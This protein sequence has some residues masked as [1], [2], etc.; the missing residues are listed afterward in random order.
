MGCRNE[1]RRP[2]KFKRALGPPYI[3]YITLYTADVGS[4]TGPLLSPTMVAV[5]RH[6][7]S[8]WIQEPTPNSI[9]LDLKIFNCDRWTSCFSNIF[10]W[11]SILYRS[12]TPGEMIRGRCWRGGLSIT[13]RVADSGPSPVM[14]WRCPCLFFQ[15]RGA[16]RA[17]FACLR[18]TGRF[19]FSDWLPEVF[20]LFW[21]LIFT[22]LHQWQSPFETETFNL[23][24][25]LP[26]H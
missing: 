1:W 8:M 22:L 4:W 15:K 25:L 26:L 11:I 5:A 13:G 21:G 24:C 12:H 19:S 18:V 10:V 3:P 9:R 14:S 16:E 6:L 17:R 23:G 2:R 7:G 20:F